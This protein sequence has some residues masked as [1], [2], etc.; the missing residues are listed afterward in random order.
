MVATINQKE[1]QFR[2]SEELT[3]QLRE[4]Y[5]E[6]ENNH[7]EK[8]GQQKYTAQEVFDKLKG[9]VTREGNLKY[10]RREGNKYG[11]LPSIQY[12]KN[13]F[14]QWARESKKKSSTVDADTNDLVDGYNDHVSDNSDDEMNEEILKQKRVPELKEMLRQRGAKVS[15]N[16]QSLI[17]R[18]L[19]K[20]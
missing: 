15:G 11:Q 20:D 9:M 10:S 13:K 4:Y 19:G 7:G 18:L 12:I 8:K 2:A 3:R 14:S 1:K 17:D 6:G 16:K 5:D